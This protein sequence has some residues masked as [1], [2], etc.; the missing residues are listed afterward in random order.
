MRLYE[1][2]VAGRGRFPIDMLRHDCCFPAS[3]VDAALVD[4]GYP[5][6]REVRLFHRDDVRWRPTTGR[7]ESFG[8]KV[9][10]CEEF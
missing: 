9:I 7:W 2:I 1:L 6:K 3:E 8:W 5:G 10:S 4:S